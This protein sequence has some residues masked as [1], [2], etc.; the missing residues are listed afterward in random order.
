LKE[1]GIANVVWTVIGMLC[2][3]FGVADDVVVNIPITWKPGTEH[4]SDLFTNTLDGPTFS[5]IKNV[6]DE[7]A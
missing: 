6:A 1:A 2:C 3:S 5:Y 7:N 4:E